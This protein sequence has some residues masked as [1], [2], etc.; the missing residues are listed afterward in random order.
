MLEVLARARS[1]SVLSRLA[2]SPASSDSNAS[3]LAKRLRA[4]PAYAYFTPALS[5]LLVGIGIN[6]L[7]LQPERHPAPFFAPAS[8]PIQPTP[9]VLPT[10]ASRLASMPR[11]GSTAAAAPVPPSHRPEPEGGGMS[12]PR[13]SDPIAELLRGGMRLE[14][15][16]LI[17]AAQNA[18]AK[19]GYG[20]KADGRAGAAT[21]QA[22]RDFERAQGLPLATEI[23]PRIVDKLTAAA[24]AAG[25]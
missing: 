3:A 7:V 1:D 20:V 21:Q 12:S 23:T 10:E 5:A 25:R 17:L 4:L 8:A 9:A 19:L 11:E 13:T 18:L 15:P 14:D 22:L 6:A 24:H 16:R 2:K